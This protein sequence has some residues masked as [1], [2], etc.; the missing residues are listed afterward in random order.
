MTLGEYAEG[1][2]AT[3]MGR[4]APNSARAYRSALEHQVLPVFGG[5]ELAAITTRDVRDWLRGLGASGKR[6]NGIKAAWSAL[7]TVLTDAVIDGEVATNAA[8]GATRRLLASRTVTPPKAMTPGELARLLIA[9]HQQCQR[10]A[11]DAFYTYSRTGLRLGEL[12]ALRQRAIS[13]ADSAIRV[14]EQFHGGRA[15]FGPPKGGKSRVVEVPP[16]CLRLLERRAEDCQGPM[17]FLFPGER[18]DRPVHPAS[19][20]RVFEETASAAGLEGYSVHSLRHT[21]ASILIASG[22]PPAWVQQ[23]MGHASYGI[24]VD[25][26]GSWLKQKRP[27]LLAILDDEPAH[28]GLLRLE[29]AKV[30][31]IRRA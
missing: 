20:D 10:W 2:L 13:V 11:A 15:G 5:H 25:L 21:Y 30:I 19:M 27:D 14:E 12:L 6:P 3:R 17:G 23:Q 24:T 18:P 28:H 29:R 26:Y 8:H 22:A 9:S 7:S 1:W 31:P 4:L 16:R